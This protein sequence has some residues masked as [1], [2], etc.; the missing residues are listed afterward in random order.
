MATRTPQPPNTNNIA[1]DL[2]AVRDLCNVRRRENCV[3]RRVGFFIPYGILV[4]DTRA[5]FS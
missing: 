2:R 4:P 1:G 5:A 3:Q